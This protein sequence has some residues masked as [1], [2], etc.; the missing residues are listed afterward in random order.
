M[1]A[2]SVHSQYTSTVRVKV[3][4]PTTLL[5]VIWYSPLSPRVTPAIVK[6]V[7]A[8]VALVSVTDVPLLVKLMR[9]GGLALS[10]KGKVNCLPSGGV[11]MAMAG[12]K[13]G[14]TGGEGDYQCLLH[15][16][17]TNTHFT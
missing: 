8:T 16:M 15:C 9:G 1:E 4:D 17:A 13:R 11:A 3:A 7:V 14:Q 6:V 2:M 10:W 5:A 12:L